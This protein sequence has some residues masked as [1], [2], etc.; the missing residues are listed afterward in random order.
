MSDLRDFP[1]AGISLAVPQGFEYQPLHEPF[2]VMRAV[3]SKGAQA[4]QAVTLSAFP[5]A[6]KV[7]AADFAD[8]MLAEQKQNLTI[9]HLKMLKQI[10]MPVA[11]IPG[12]AQ[13]I[14]YTFRGIET[15]AARVYFIRELAAS[16]VRIC[17]VLTV[18]TDMENQVS[19]LPILGEVIKTVGLTAVQRPVTV[20]IRQLHRPMKDHKRGYIVRPPL[21]WYTKPGPAGLE[22]GQVDYLLGGIPMPTVTVTVTE[23]PSDA[24]SE[25]CTKKCLKLALA[26]AAEQNLRVEVV[27]EGPARL[28]GLAGWQFALRQS[29]EPRP[30]TG[31]ADNQQHPVVIVQRTVCPPAEPG[32]EK[33]S[34]SLVLICQGADAET[35]MGMM[36]KIAGGFEFAG[37]PSASITASAPA[38]KK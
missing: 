28:G 19:L 37:R 17:Y 9:R 6:P 11:G 32:R 38:K 23:V 29:Q 34:Y 20:A 8:A 13:R 24:T 25:Q 31:P 30:S 3:L 5:V 33:N 18:E 35:A 1:H 16:K 21:G 7:T 15:T 14:S 2:N 26:A 10:P 22:M 27:A 12:V 4:A 36:E